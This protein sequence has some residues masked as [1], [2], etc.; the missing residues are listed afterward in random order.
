MT[1]P[2]IGSLCTGHGGL[3][4]AVQAVYGGRTVWHADPDPGVTAI[5]AHHW[6]GVPNLGDIAAV[7]WSAQEPVEILTAG[8]PCEDV[9]LSG[10]RKGL[11]AGTRSGLWSEVARAI[12]EIRPSL[13]VIE[14]VLGILSSPADGDVEPCPRCLGDGGGLPLR[15]LGAVLAGLA[16]RG[17]DAEWGC[18]AASAIGACHQRRRV[19][20]LAWPAHPRDAQRP[21]PAGRQG[22]PG[23]VREYGAAPAPAHAQDLGQQRGGGPRQRRA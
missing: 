14:N 6:P 13:V 1:G 10:L 4:A 15:A 23:D 3:D 5:L 20:V 21:Q 9:S 7:D 22:R 2:R 17:F 12:R 8:F 11:A 16:E 18:L 19:F